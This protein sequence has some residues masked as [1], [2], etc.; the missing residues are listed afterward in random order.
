MSTLTIS[1][2]HFIAYI[3]A[4]PIAVVIHWFMLRAT[5]RYLS[6]A[7]PWKLSGTWLFAGV[8]GTNAASLLHAVFKRGNCVIGSTLCIP[9][10]FRR[11]WPFPYLGLQGFE[12]VVFPIFF[13]L[14]TLFWSGSVCALLCLHTLLIA[15]ANSPVVRQ[16]STALVTGA[17]ILAAYLL[18]YQI[19]AFFP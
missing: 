3:A 12:G 19:G 13:S 8:A 15:R 7:L 18:P 2:G 14:T 5:Y 9:D 16:L 11:G 1:I 4:I 17:M 6:T 10:T